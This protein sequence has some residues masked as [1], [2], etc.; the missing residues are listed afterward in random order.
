[1]R[2]ALLIP[3]LWVCCSCSQAGR[4]VGAAPADLAQPE[5]IEVLFNHRDGRRYRSPLTGAWR[6]GDDLEQTLVDAIDA[7]E[8]EVLVAIQQ[9]TLPR[10]AK[11]LIACLLYTSP[12]PRD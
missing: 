10:I 9:L 2:N 8:S 1:M 12:S 5:G 7:A 11:A 3:L 4:I 6:N